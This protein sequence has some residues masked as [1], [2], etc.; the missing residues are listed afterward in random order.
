MTMPKGYA[1][2]KYCDRCSHT[3]TQHTKEL[4]IN[5][6]TMPKGIKLTES[7]TEVNHTACNL[8]DCTTY[9]DK[10]VIKFQ[11]QEL[12]RQQERRLMAQYVQ[13]QQLQQQQRS[14]QQQQPQQIKMRR[15]D[16]SW[17]YYSSN[18]YVMPAEYTGSSDDTSNNS[19]DTT[20][21]VDTVEGDYEF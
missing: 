16:G 12:V 2:F 3:D 20:T 5:R 13:Q 14:R 7:M 21:D 8:C 6:G 10:E 11:Q 17:F 18:T 19:N 4:I 9:I 1:S 15:S